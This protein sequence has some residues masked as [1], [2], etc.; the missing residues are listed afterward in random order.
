VL[1]LNCAVS[2]IAFA[3]PTREVLIADRSEDWL[4]F[5][6][7]K[8][9]YLPF[10]PEMHTETKI[11]IH[12]IIDLSEH[13]KGFFYFRIRK[14][15]HIY[16]NNLLIK[17]AQKEEWTELDAAKLTSY[18]STVLLTLYG[19]KKFSTPPVFYHTSV[20]QSE[21]EL[22]PERDKSGV[23]IKKSKSLDFRDFSILTTILLL[24]LIAFAKKWTDPVFD[25]KMWLEKIADFI[26]PVRFSVKMNMLDLL[27]FVLLSS[28]VLSHT[29]MIFGQFDT[30]FGSKAVSSEEYKGIWDFSK[31]YLSTFL[32]VAFVFVVKYFLVLFA[33]QLQFTNKQVVQI[34]TQV[35]VRYGKIFLA[36][37]FILSALLSF[38]ALKNGAILLNS[39]LLMMIF[40]LVLHAAI[41]SFFVFRTLSLKKL[42]LF[43]YLCATEFVPLF[44]II[45]LFF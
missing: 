10:L 41:V 43:S 19:E 1:F 18:G 27:V 39:A 40:G 12:Q 29:I 22:A 28:L 31:T 30:Y 33:A 6:A 25:S 36:I 35:F 42:Y 32:I 20:K 21:N 8:K 44:L 16:L 14:G 38:S 3:V 7:D 24:L 26:R 45:K 15:E 4:F 13:N 9:K 34:H 23:L 17:I 11:P 2:E 5:D 37:N